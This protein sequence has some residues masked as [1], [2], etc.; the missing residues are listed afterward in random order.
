MMSH[1]NSAARESLAGH[2]P[3]DLARIFLPEELLRH[4]GLKEIHPDNVI[5]KP[6]LLK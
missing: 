5:L 2:T 4:F 3:M 1:I 6:S